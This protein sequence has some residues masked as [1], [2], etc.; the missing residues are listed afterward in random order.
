VPRPSPETPEVGWFTYE[1]ARA[2][3]TDDAP[4]SRLDDALSA[5]DGVL[6]RRFTS[7]PYEVHHAVE[8][9]PR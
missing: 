3:V 8:L 1:E 7:R 9:R 4:A 6:V 5:S 2:M